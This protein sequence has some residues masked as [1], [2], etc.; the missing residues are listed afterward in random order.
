M[1]DDKSAHKRGVE[2]WRKHI[3]MTTWI[4]YASFYLCRTNISIAIPGIMAE[5]AITKTQMGGV[6]SSLFIAYAIGQFI[7]GQFADKFGARK[8]ITIGILLSAVMN[9]IFG[10]IGGILILMMVV[11]ALNGY[12]QSMGWSSCVKTIA[13]WFPLKRRG[14]TCGILGTSYQMGN[15]LSWLL[16]GFIIGNFGWRFGFW[17]PALIFIA[18]GIFWYRKAK[19]APEEVGLPTIEEEERGIAAGDIR[20]DHH[21]GFKKTA[22]M[23]LLNPYIWAVGLGLLCLNIIRYGFL[24]WVPTY[25]FEVQKLSISTAA[26]KSL[27]LPFAGSLGAL[28]AGYISDKIFKSKRSPVIVLMLLLLVLF[29]WIYPQIPVG[30]WLSGILV[31]M[32]IGFM[33]YGP[34][35]I[36]VTA[37]PMDYGTRKAAGSATGFIDGMGYIGASITGITS[38]WL[39]DTFGWSAAFDFWIAAAIAAAIIMILVWKFRKTE[40]TNVCVE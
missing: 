11:W 24:D 5:F 37:M 39:I 12:F 40:N 19:N 29:T 16:G 1:I 2:S 31:L 9:I 22:K 21:I 13:N 10:F 26:Y 17:V 7:N 35:V 28:S 4:A 27:L 8:M 38:G 18:V 14:K 33:L 34:H 20:K 6:L 23:T 32:A 36:M 15:V 3:L 30:D 25:M